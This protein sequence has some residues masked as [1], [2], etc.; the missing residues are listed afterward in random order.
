MVINHECNIRRSFRLGSRPVSILLL[1]NSQFREV[2]KRHPRLSRPLFVLPLRTI[3]PQP[4]TPLHLLAIQRLH[5]PPR[6]LRSRQIH[7]EVKVVPWL[8]GFGRMWGNHFANGLDF[9]SVEN[10]LHLGVDSRLVVDFG[11]P[12]NV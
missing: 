10:S 6:L 3:H 5:R 8:A 12:A 7:K 1:R 9:E 2:V 4:P 11:K